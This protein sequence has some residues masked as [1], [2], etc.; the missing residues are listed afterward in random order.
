MEA[1]IVD[2]LNLL[3]RWLHLVSGVAWIGASFYFVM[4]D[5]SLSPPQR[6]E[7]AKRG[8][9]GELWAVHGGGF[10]N[11]QKYL[12]GPKGEP[13]AANLHWSKWEAYTTWLSGMG[14]LAI[15][16][17]YGA[18]SYLIDKSVLALSPVAAIALSIAFLIGGWLV[19]DLLC[20]LLTGRENLLAGAMLL[21]VM[22][23]AW[24][25]FHVFG[26]RA[27]FV[28][29]GAM[30][31]TMMVANVYFH[32]I[33]GQK[34]M[35]ADI[36]AG[37]EPDATPGLIGKQRSVHNTYFTLPVLFVMISNHYPMT[38]SHPKGWIVLGVI[39]L[40]GVLIRQ[41]FVFRHKG[42]TAWLL[43]VLAAGLLLGLAVALAPTPT[44][45]VSGEV[46]FAKVKAVLDARCIGCHAAQP[47]QAGFAQPPK[48]ILLETPEQIGQNAAKIVETVGN[49][50]MPI[51]NLTQMS[52]DERAIVA[53][54]FA[55][56]AKR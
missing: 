38:Y 47:T 19:Y 43:P 26:A 34:R 33:P 42:R 44:L 10:Y 40:A 50:Y 5:N 17:W 18:S 7:D 1:Y 22:A 48:G 31:G 9:F 24:A 8:V 13:L 53:A 46:P 11:S 12:T 4:L 39:M 28:H 29:V 27:A 25:L 23:A 52:D 54:W 32:I 55:Q 56:G 20:R 30:I 41:F 36:R 16:Y 37:R 49:R 35:V 15:I 6:P 21:L 14:L 51:G 45:A 2:W 3:V